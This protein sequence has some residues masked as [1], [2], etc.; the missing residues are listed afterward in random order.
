MKRVELERWLRAHG[1]E[2]V[3]G[4]SGG[5]HEACQHIDSRAKSFVPRHREIG[6]DDSAAAGVRSSFTG[7][8]STFVVMLARV[9]A[10]E[11]DGKKA[12]RS[13]RWPRHTQHRVCS[14]LG[15]PGL[16]R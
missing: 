11:R 12:L 14:L 5:G 10:E 16:P 7:V 15:T 8:G 4:R 2:P 3:A 13:S 1:A 9:L 6:D